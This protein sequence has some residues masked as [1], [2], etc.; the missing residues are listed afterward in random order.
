MT[1]ADAESSTPPQSKVQQ[2]LDAIEDAEISPEEGLQIALALVN[3]VE[4]FH[5]EALEELLQAE[6]Q[7]AMSVAVWAADSARLETVRQLLSAVL[8]D[9]DDDEDDLEAE[10]DGQADDF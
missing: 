7:E 3:F 8:G 10:E 9:D 4:E 1:I 6:Q 5:L 2:V